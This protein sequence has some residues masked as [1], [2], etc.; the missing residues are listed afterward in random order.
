MLPAAFLVDCQKTLK[1]EPTG[2]EAADS[3]RIDCG[4]AA[5]NRQDFYVVFCTQPDE[6]FTGV[7]N[8]RGTGIRY[9]SA[10]LACK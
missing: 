4:A 6:I 7:R 9:Q 1:G 10:G 8:G 3:Q 2:G 5:G